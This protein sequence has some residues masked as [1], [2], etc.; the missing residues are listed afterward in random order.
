MQAAEISESSPQICSVHSH[1][2]ATQ[3]PLWLPDPN[4]LSHRGGGQSHLWPPLPAELQISKKTAACPSV[5][6][7]ETDAQEWEL[8]ARAE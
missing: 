4:L 6:G 3:F 8:E 1:P 5:Q 7:E 2:T